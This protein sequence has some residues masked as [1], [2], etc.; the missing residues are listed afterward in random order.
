METK[1]TSR[2]RKRTAQQAIMQ[3][4]V[5]DDPDYRPTDNRHS[6][7]NSK[8]TTEAAAENDPDYSP[9]ERTGAAPAAIEAAEDEL[10]KCSLC[11]RGYR[12]YRSYK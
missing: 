8:R 11:S 10:W 6:R 9:G 7:P 1:H 12:S 2:G 4:D 3:D 5:E